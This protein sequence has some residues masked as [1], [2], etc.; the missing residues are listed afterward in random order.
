MT[1]KR[2][3]AAIASAAPW[4]GLSSGG[5]LYGFDGEN[6]CLLRQLS[7]TWVSGASPRSQNLSRLPIPRGLLRS[8][9]PFF[10]IPHLGPGRLARHRETMKHRNAPLWIGPAL[11]RP[12][13]AVKRLKRSGWCRTSCVWC[14]PLFNSTL[15]FVE[16]PRSILHEAWRHLISPAASMARSPL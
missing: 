2:V 13:P 14:I 9:S 1:R 16:S 10:G 12:G 6:N 8:R 4:N 11:D 15:S 3:N 7:N 5:S